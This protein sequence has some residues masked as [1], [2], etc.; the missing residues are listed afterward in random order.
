MKNLTKYYI[1]FFSCL[2]MLGSSILSSGTVVTSVANGNW[3]NPSNWSSFPIPVLPA[4]TVIINHNIILDTDWGSFASVT[5]NPGASLIENVPGRNYGVVSG[6]FTNGG[7]MEISRFGI[8]SGV[9][10]NNDSMRMDISFANLGNFTNNGTMYAMDSFYN[11]GVFVNG[12][13]G[14]IDAMEFWSSDTLDNSGVINTINFL[15]TG[16]FLNNGPVTSTDFLNSSDFINNTSLVVFNDF[17]NTGYFY[18]S[19]AATVIIDFDF[20]NSNLTPAVFVN[21][22]SVSVFDD[23]SNTDTI[24]GNAPGQFCVIDSTYNT[25]VMSGDFD[26]C[27][28]SGGA[29]DLN[30]GT[31]DINITYCTVVCITSVEDNDKSY[32]NIRVYPNPTINSS[33]LEF[34]N[35]KGEKYVLTLYN[36]IGQLVR[37]IDNITTGKIRLERMNLTSGMYFFLLRKDAGMI[38]NG[39]LIIE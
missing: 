3:T 25:G 23:W 26:F 18:N 6:T 4:D 21:D 28:I 35:S 17:Y 24:Y 38:G 29:I 32:S 5:V 15:S 2:I 10:T 19:S 31:V 13:N 9:V 33:T 30:L 8:L 39:K 36:N 11:G 34:D 16:Y 37:R 22:G 14:V 7:T 1:I 12:P 20:L 27:D